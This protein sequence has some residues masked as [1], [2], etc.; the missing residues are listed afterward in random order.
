[1]PLLPGD[2]VR[3]E[4]GRLEIM[5]A[6]G[7]TLA[8]DRETSVD[9]QADD[10]VRVKDG[11]VRLTIP[12]PMRS[13]SF[14]VDSPAGS[15]RV[16]EAGEYRIRML[17]GSSSA[18]STEAE[19]QIE[20]AVVYGA[21]DLFTDE[22]ST[23]VRAGESAYASAGLLPSYAYAFN[24]ASTDD[25]DRWVEGQPEES[26]GTSAQYLPGDM[27]EYSTTFDEYGDWQYMPSYGYVWYP[28]VAAAWRPY[29][30]GRWVSYP[31]YGWTWIGADAFA[32]PTH[33]YGRWGYNAG[34]W[35]WIPASRWAP[36]YVS[37]AYAPG[38]V[39]WCPLGFD[40]RPVIGISINIGRRYYS[41]WNAW[42]VVNASHFGRGYVP[43]RVVR[44]AA[45]STGTHP[46]FQI[47]QTGP[48]IRDVAVPRYVNRGDAIVQSQT[49]RPAGPARSASVGVDTNRSVAVP[50]SQPG[51]AAY[52]VDRGQGAA[53]STVPVYR[54]T[55]PRA[56]SV[57]MYRTAPPSTTVSPSRARQTEPLYQPRGS[58]RYGNSAPNDA[59]RYQPNAIPRYAPRQAPGIERVV[60]RGSAIMR[61]APPA[62]MPGPPPATAGT[63]IMRSAPP[64]GARP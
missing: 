10:L 3:T 57:P 19:T 45:W 58:R 1:M 42:T 60:P 21:A 30:Y 2:R 35:F 54:G 36:A 22:G 18:S 9:F 20:L 51:G 44:T 25:F 56:S 38:Y 14:R 5:L 12:A 43:E 53:P 27:R 13:P 55:V 33:H 39:S 63:A 46:A 29:Y 34:L 61:S 49:A 7:G 23:R 37:W 64:A 6:N 59:P 11:R 47:R 50:R 24:T 48:A 62:A 4:D 16:A 26:V 40:N 41:P 8:V 31:R 17:H 28:R 52:R 15:V 32:W